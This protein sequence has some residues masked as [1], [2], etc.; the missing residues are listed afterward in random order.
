MA[1]NNLADCR[2][3]PLQLPI[4]ISA[5]FETSL[6]HLNSV[7]LRAFTYKHVRRK[8]FLEI[9]FEYLGHNKISSILNIC[10]I[11]SVLFPAKCISFHYAN[12]HISHKPCTK[13]KYPPW[14]NK[15]KKKFRSWLQ[16]FILVSG[17]QSKH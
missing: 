10:S 5:F 2:R 4:L 14:Q 1:L 16:H 8:T 6:L 9:C 3:I 12:P 7:F 11:L 17:Y 13:F 15:G